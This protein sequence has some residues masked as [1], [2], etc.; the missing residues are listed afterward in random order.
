MEIWYYF[1]LAVFLGSC[2]T[3]YKAWTSGNTGHTSGFGNGLVGALFTL[4]AVAAAG[5]AGITFIIS[6]FF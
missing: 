1:L 4:I 2:I 3:A 5:L 6:L